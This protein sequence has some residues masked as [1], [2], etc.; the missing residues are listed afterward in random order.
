MRLDGE[1][2]YDGPRSTGAPKA[3]VDYKLPTS[4]IQAQ[5]GTKEDVQKAIEELRKALPHEGAVNVDPN[6]LKMYGSSD[7]SY[8]PAS[9]QSVV[10]RPEST[11][12]VRVPCITPATGIV[13]VVDRRAQI[14][15]K[16]A[17][18]TASN[19]SAFR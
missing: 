11:E 12:D 3:K 17:S 15:M 19:A 7:K 8:H 10:V 13:P 2:A 18:S 16:A 5:Y 4:S 1:A 6:V 14:G 9:P